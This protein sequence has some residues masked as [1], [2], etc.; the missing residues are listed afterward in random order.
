MKR[1]L[2]NNGKV[3]IRND[4]IVK[5]NALLLINAKIIAWQIVCKECLQIGKY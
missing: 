1:V 4:K 2:L 3:I 5:K